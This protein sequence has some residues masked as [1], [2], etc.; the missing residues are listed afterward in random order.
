MSK[1]GKKKDSS[2]R[3]NSGS[4]KNENV[5]SSY[6]QAPAGSLVGSV[7]SVD[8]K[9]KIR[10]YPLWP[11]FVENDINTEKWESGGGKAKEKGK[12]P[13]PQ[14]FDDPEGK[15][16]MPS[17]IEVDHW[18][19][20]HDFLNGKQ[21]V[22]VEKESSIDILHPNEHLCH[23]EVMRTIISQISSLW[24]LSRERSEVKVTPQN[25]PASSELGDE[26][27]KPWEHIYSL[28][29]AGKGHMPLHNQYGKYIVRLYWMGCWR[30]IVVDD[31]LPFD[32][33][34]R[35]LLP[36]TT[37][38]VELWPML[39]AKALIKVASID[40]NV[41]DGPTEIGDYFVMHCLTGWLPET[42]PLQ[43]SHNENLWE[44]LKKVLPEWKLPE[45]KP[46]E[47]ESDVTPA[48]AVSSKKN[49]SSVAKH[50]N[51]GSAATKPDKGIAKDAKTNKDG[52]KK[53]DD[54]EKQKA[55]SEVPTKPERVEMIVF[56][57]FNQQLD[58][59]TSLSGLR[60]MANASEKLR[61]VG[62]SNL[63]P[64][65]VLI[66]KTRS[67]SLV[68]PTPVPEI[69]RW[70]LIRPRKKKSTPFDEPQ[71]EP[72]PPKPDQWLE[73]VSPYLGHRV[74]PLNIERSSRPRSHIS[75]V[76]DLNEI[77]E[78][79]EYSD[80]PKIKSPTKQVNLPPISR[81]RLLTEN[82]TSVP[83][84]PKTKDG[85]RSLEG[86]DVAGGQEEE[87]EEE[88]NE[89]KEEDAQQDGMLENAE[90]N[91]ATWID[92]D[93]FCK[94]FTNV[95]IFHKP[96]TY[97]HNGTDTELKQVALNAGLNVA[98][99]GSKKG[100]AQVNQTPSNTNIGKTGLITPKSYEGFPP[101]ERT[102]SFLFVDNLQPTEL[103]VSFSVLPRWPGID[104]RKISD[105]ESV[106]GASEVASTK[107]EAQGLSSGLLVAEP[108]S[109]KSLLTG[110]PV[111]RIRTTGTRAACLTLPAGR[112]VL[113]FLFNSPLGYH[114][115]I[116]STISFVYGDK[117]T[118]MA[119]LQEESCRFVESANMIM[120]AVEKC[121]NAIGERKRWK[122]AFDE[123]HKAHMPYH[124]NNKNQLNR[125][126]QGW[127]RAFYSTMNAVMGDTKVSALEF[128][129]R[130]IFLDCNPHAP[131]KPSIA[132][133]D[134][135]ENWM[136]RTASEEEE[137][138]VKL[139]QKNWRGTYTRKL[140]D[141]HQVPGS[142]EHLTVQEALKT[143]KSTLHANNQAHSL[144]LLR[145]ILK[146]N[147]ELVE[148]FPFHNDE[149]NKISFTDY[150]GTF[151][152]QP[153][154]S[155]FVVFRETFHVE[156]DMLCV[157]KIYVPIPT[158]LLRVVDNDSG[159]EVK[160]VFQRVAPHV[161]KKNKRGYTFVAEAWTLDQ[162][163]ISNK[164]RMRLIGSS[165]NLPAPINNQLTAQFSVKE[166]KDYYVPN[167]GNILLR[168][169]VKCSANHI[170]SLQLETSKPDVHIKFQ[171]L[172]NEEEIIST[173]GKG[174][175]VIPAFYFQAN[176]P[177]RSQ[178]RL[179]NQESGQSITQTSKQA[180]AGKKQGGSAKPT[181]EKSSQKESRR[182]SIESRVP[183]IPEDSVTDLQSH[184]Y[185]IQAVVERKSWPLTR[186]QWSFVQKLRE[187]EKEEIKAFSAHKDRS[188]SP[189]ARDRQGGGGKPA[190]DKGKK[191]SKDAGKG[192]K[193]KKQ[194][195]KEAG[196]RPP[197]QNVY[198]DSRA[199]FTLRF[200]SDLER[201]ED[202][203]I[204]KDTKRQ[205]EI[206]AMKQA[207]EAA[208]PG[209][210]I[211]AMQSR[212]SY[213]NNNTAK[214]DSSDKE[215][216]DENPTA[217]ESVT[218]PSP[219]LPDDKEIFST[220]P[221]TAT[222][223]K[224]LL[225]PFDSTP[226]LS[227]RARSDVIPEYVDAE[228]LAQLEEEEQ[229]RRAEDHME[230]RSRSL[231]FREENRVDRTILKEQQLET[232]L[233]MQFALDKS[234]TELLKP[235]EEYRQA[236][237]EQKRFREE[238]AAAATA[239]LSA[240]E[241]VSPDPKGKKSAGKRKK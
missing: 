96:S 147:P 137:A 217:T 108:Y 155:W 211:K 2:N 189:G 11:E 153:P 48:S 204:K 27:W 194:H 149:W 45:E 93:E 198:D 164:W 142:R 9:G 172:N 107:Q 34:D 150:Q 148:K 80:T 210:A 61:K 200:V 86:S 138:A 69:P 46:T 110:Q 14:F 47:H 51:T 190:T 62:L 94:S 201:S 32:A 182:E 212:L 165:A 136:Q 221:S 6:A 99:S 183:P 72:E 238:E 192:G 234:R 60:E 132:S 7:A 163:L 174:H 30:K 232:C 58:Q 161:Y 22:I 105:K 181:E 42:I 118:V 228:R 56:A 54:K 213:I 89:Q 143:L 140:L 17:S 227:G 197:S 141:A 214:A 91:K 202:V 125:H 215:N 160:R 84:T 1:A 53:K 21:P 10:N 79:E 226:Y 76:H 199:Y 177:K 71:A 13:S 104:D 117:D 195:D 24:S 59:P 162:A 88:E 186:G 116:C 122:E 126:Y 18:Q 151:P 97:A 216:E 103:I 8:S 73:I 37:K 12:S 145:S 44:L 240:S 119:P 3:I 50:D 167:K 219:E 40:Y 130:A 205:E 19:R 224:T 139:L 68:P 81:E 169:H 33:D 15:I 159:E 23:S 156:E 171:I 5:A 158:C 55:S 52:T 92:F 82:D 20:P 115:H 191:G 170:G 152:D 74:V 193:E 144:A 41:N 229:K 133:K 223:A 100:S 70:K 102:P 178:S 225:V 38:E 185:T 90:I 207:W 179:S 196:S 120:A 57:S 123:L 49:E 25:S 83:Q 101:E 67:C 235:R 135:P 206:R 98:P 131:V 64:H 209:R 184:V 231:A 29:K 26:S 36:A 121:I 35:L 4:N 208:E 28:C 173:R 239:A 176:E 166:V 113:R 66:A 95:T 222:S 112:H 128:A 39:L 236:L 220:P 77:E 31:L 230:K 168:Y 78:H 127:Y 114:L 87:G 187:I 85:D 75:G 188:G 175:C 43:Y 106:A 109:W 154:R 134:T 65:P 237:L 180:T 218:A 16:E 233:E 157:P 241:P 124:A 203:D 146:E 129:L 111:L 63:H